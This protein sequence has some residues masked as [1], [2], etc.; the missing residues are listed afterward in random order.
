MSSPMLQLGDQILLGGF[1]PSNRI[2][3]LDKDILLA[4][5]GSEGLQFGY[6]VFE[7]IKVLNGKC[8]F[9][10]EHLERMILSASILGIPYEAFNDYVKG[11][12]WHHQLSHFIE[13]DEAASLKIMLLK[14]SETTCFWILI[15]KPYT[16]KEDMYATGFHCKLGG[17]LRNEN[18]KWVF[19]K[20]LN[21]GE[22]IAMKQSLEDA[23]SEWLWRNS[24]G[25]LTEGTIGNIFFKRGTRWFTPETKSGILNGVTRQKLIAYLKAQQI[26]VVEACFGPEVLYQADRV[27]LTNSLMGLM[28][29]R[30]FEQ[31]KFEIDLDE[32]WRINRAL[33]IW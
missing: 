1:G 17:K 15:K 30:Y 14:R 8:I 21:Y 13:K 11:E 29:V 33:G 3:D 20:T 32:I 27:Y 9:L 25:D 31:V 18:S 7:T 23:Q 10:E 22:N 24:K 28:P 26:D 19:H 5:V 2:E 6:G 4:I 16:Y 12:I